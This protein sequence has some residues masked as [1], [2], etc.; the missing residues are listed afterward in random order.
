MELV[1]NMESPRLIKTHLSFDMLP[2]SI[3]EN[4]AKVSK[5][6]NFFFLLSQIAFFDRVKIDPICKCNLLFS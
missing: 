5:K 6:L 2:T 1:E 4:K 3:T